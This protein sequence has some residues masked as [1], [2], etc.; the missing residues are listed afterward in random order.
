[1]TRF[2]LFVGLAAM[3]AAFAAGWEVKGWR[4]DKVISDMAAEASAQ[5]S[6][7]WAEEAQGN[8][9]AL[10]EREETIKQIT[11]ANHNLSQKLRTAYAKDPETRALADTC[12]PDSI[13]CLLQ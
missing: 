3:L 11:E 5:A 7:A 10:A 9:K 2:K 1:M 4:A 6:A 13:I 12:L 8:R